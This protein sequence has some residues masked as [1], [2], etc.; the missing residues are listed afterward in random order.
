MADDNNE[1]SP[2]FVEH[3][4]ALKARQDAL[5]GFENSVL[6]TEAA[7]KATEARGYEV[8]PESFQVNR[9]ESERDRLDAFAQSP[10][11]TAPPEL[12]AYFIGVE[13]AERNRADEAFRDITAVQIMRT[14]EAKQETLPLREAPSGL[15]WPKGEQLPPRW[16]NGLFLRKEELREW[17]KEHCHDLLGSALLTAPPATAP[18]A[19]AATST[20]SADDQQATEGNPTGVWWRDEYDVLLLAQNA[21]DSLFRQKK[22]TSIRA[23]ANAVAKRIEDEELRGQR[24]KVSGDTIRNTVLLGWKYRRD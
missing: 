19:D 14:F 16:S 24:R 22:K 6:R 3:L 17:A 4:K 8:K 11:W 23:I 20:G 21:G 9:Y 1:F 7:R 2:E 5:G 10:T 15:L 13:L 12:W 18:Q